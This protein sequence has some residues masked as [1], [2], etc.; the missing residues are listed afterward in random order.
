[1][2]FGSSYDDKMFHCDI[3]QNSNQNDYHW[4][5]NKL[6]MPHSVDFDPYNVVLGFANVIFTFYFPFG[7]HSDIH[8]FDLLNHQWFKSKYNV[9]ECIG[10]F[11]NI[12]VMKI[13][14]YRCLLPYFHRIY[15]QRGNTCICTVC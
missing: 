8:C 9:P 6:K 13:Q 15:T 4:K 2:I 10:S 1:M 5:L 3:E 14:L 12:Y 7:G 11:Y